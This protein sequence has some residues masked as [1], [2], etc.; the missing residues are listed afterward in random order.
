MSDL[1]SPG[2]I[3][4]RAL[5]AYKL[6]VQV[7]RLAWRFAR[8]E[9]HV[10]GPECEEPRRLW[11]YSQRQLAKQYGGRLDDRRGEFHG[12]DWAIAR[13]INRRHPLWRLNDRLASMW[14]GRWRCDD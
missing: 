6:H 14:L 13:R 11:E 10:C 9:P 8:P 7:N 2:D 12:P 3:P 4:I 5:I 1:W